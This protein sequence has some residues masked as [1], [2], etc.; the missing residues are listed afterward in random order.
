MN[1]VGGRFATARRAFAGGSCAAPTP[2]APA[3][4]YEGNCGPATS[5]SQVSL[6]PKFAIGSNA[7]RRASPGVPGQLA[8][9]A[10]PITAATAA[11]ATNPRAIRR[12]D[13]MDGSFEGRAYTRPG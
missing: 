9:A 8:P 1:V 11:A 13:N 4:A 2:T 7:T 12:G 5:H 6:A 3:A 10:R